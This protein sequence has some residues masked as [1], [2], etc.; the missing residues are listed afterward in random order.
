MALR[1]PGARTRGDAAPHIQREAAH[2]R[3]TGFTM[4]AAAAALAAALAP[5]LGPLLTAYW[6]LAAGSVVATLLPLPLPQAFKDA[7]AL[8][9][10]RGKLWQTKP[11]A[12]GPLRDW[13]VPQRWFLHFYVVGAACNAAALAALACG[14]C[15]GGSGRGGSA[16]AAA[17]AAVD[18]ATARA[19]LALA[20]FEA[21]LLR[22]ALETA[23]VMRYP[24]GAR[25]HGIAYL[26]GLRW[27]VAT[28]PC[29]LPCCWLLAVGP[30][31]LEKNTRPC[32]PKLSPVHHRHQITTTTTTI[33]ITS[34]LL[35]RR[36]AVAA[37]ARPPR[38]A[39]GGAAR[40]AQS[41]GS[42]AA[43][44]RPGSVRG[45]GARGGAVAAAAARPLGRRARGR[46][47]TLFFPHFWML[48][49]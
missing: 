11:D 29:L 32:C 8:S 34:Q 48:H 10:A 43:G 5:L 24:P 21:H 22:R 12:L 40:G 25:M 6:V 38:G 35:R 33:I 1:S 4:A 39:A 30:Q 37:A 28:A 18:A 45:G 44:A 27:A 26:F 9:A 41:G 23:F 19:L 31:R 17:V 49:P 13:A 3:A 7:V 47:E 16:A 15:G 20:L 42:G 36:A 14:C 2:N 46:G